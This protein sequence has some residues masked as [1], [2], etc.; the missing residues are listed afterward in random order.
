M[1]GDFLICNIITFIQFV[2]RPTYNTASFIMGIQPSPEQV[3]SILQFTM[4]FR[5]LLMFSWFW[6]VLSLLLA[7][8][9]FLLGNLTEPGHQGLAMIVVFMPFLGDLTEC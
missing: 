4:K 8:L 3:R 1:S 2:Y 6:A 7:L 5:W 9:L